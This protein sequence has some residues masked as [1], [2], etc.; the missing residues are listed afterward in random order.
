MD[1]N[2]NLLPANAEPSTAETRDE[3]DWSPYQDRVAFELADLLYTKEQMSAGNI[4]SILE[5]WTASLARFNTA[6]PFRNHADLYD[7]IDDT[8]LGGV[9]W[10]SFNI[11]YN[12]ARP[13]NDSDVPPWMK[14]KHSVFFRDPLEIAHN[15]LSN[16]DFKDEIDF[17]PLREFGPG[18]TRRLRNFM[19]GEWAWNEA[20]SAS[21]ASKSHCFIDSCS[22]KIRIS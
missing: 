8:P 15:M 9:R 7:T 6:P 14:D 19:G 21:I 12:G 11:T 10:Q 4:N 16:P 2:G 1:R 17:A 18:S 5:L 22:V 13:D 20:V 3:N